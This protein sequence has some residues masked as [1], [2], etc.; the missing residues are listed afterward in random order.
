MH[1]TVGVFLRAFMNVYHSVIG[2][3]TAYHPPELIIML[4]HQSPVLIQYRATWIHWCWVGG[5]YILAQN[6][7]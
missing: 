7:D 2:E 6:G 4:L 1:G 3:R 5:L